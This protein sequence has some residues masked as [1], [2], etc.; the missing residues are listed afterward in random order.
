MKTANP[1]SQPGARHDAAD[2]ARLIRDGDDHIRHG[3]GTQADT[4]FRKVLEHQP[5]NPEAL[6]WRGFIAFLRGD[7]HEAVE[8]LRRAIA[9]RSDDATLCGHLASALM[10][11]GNLDEAISYWQRALELAPE[12]AT[13]HGKLGDARAAFDRVEHQRRRLVGR[14]AQHPFMYRMSER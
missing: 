1:D 13:A 6:Q 9:I 5:D 7:P 3:R 8:L 11:C 12:Y 10:A 14:Q 4:C 2:I